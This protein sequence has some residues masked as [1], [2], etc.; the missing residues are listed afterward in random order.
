MVDSH[1]RNGHTLGLENGFGL[2]DDKKKNLSHFGEKTCRPSM[3]FGFLSF[4]GWLNCELKVWVRK[5]CTKLGLKTYQTPD[6]LEN[7]DRQN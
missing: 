6:I 2:G 1:E 3:T 5:I 4:L 7:I